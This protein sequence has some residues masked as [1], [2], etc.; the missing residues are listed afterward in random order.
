M[1]EENFTIIKEPLAIARGSLGHLIDVVE[2]C[3]WF[4][5][6]IYLSQST[7]QDIFQSFGKISLD[8]LLSQGDISLLE[9][10][11]KHMN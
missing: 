4:V 6:T 10:M 1:D 9:E 8:F 3:G 11:K 2:V 5:I 7:F